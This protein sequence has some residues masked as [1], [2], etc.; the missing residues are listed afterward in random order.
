MMRTS[1]LAL[2]LAAVLVT[3]AGAQETDTRAA[4]LAKLRREVETMS[5]QL[6][7]ANEDLRSQLKAIE[8]QKVEIQVQI[9][10]EELR[11]AQIEGEATARKTELE[12]FSTRGAELGPAVHESIR[13]IRAAVETGLPFHL[14]ERLA[15]LDELDKQLAAGTMTPEAA[16]ARLWAFTEDELRLARENGLDR[17][18]VLVE[19]AEVLAD[20][21]RLGM[22]ALYFRTDG[23]AVGTAVR[24]A[25]GTWTWQTLEGRDAQKSVGTL[26]EK[27]AHGIRNGSFVL[28]N[29]GATP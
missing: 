12:A 2:G 21:A 18:V 10:R 23:G 24:K 13:K 25:D 11:L 26:F 29:P 22:V 16:T 17:Q 9:R 6:T 20:V 7:L 5:Q 1:L 3:D 8:A 28:P 19:G 14:T 15:E 27:L 4:E